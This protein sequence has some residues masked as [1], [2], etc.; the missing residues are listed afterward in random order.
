MFV[1]LCFAAEIVNG[2]Y[3]V[4]GVQVGKNVDGDVAEGAGTENLVWWQGGGG[5]GAK[6]KGIGEGNERG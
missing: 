2:G 3:V 4:S 1:S 6:V 5:H